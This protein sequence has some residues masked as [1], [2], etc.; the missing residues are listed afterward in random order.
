MISSKVF[1]LCFSNPLC[2]AVGASHAAAIQDHALGVIIVVSH[3][4]GVL[5][6]GSTVAAEVVF[7]A[8]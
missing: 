8:C 4:I 1:V 7:F 3:Y 2:S 5:I 6:Y